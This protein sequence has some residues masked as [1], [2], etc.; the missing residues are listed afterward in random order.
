MLKQVNLYN[1]PRNTGHKAPAL[2]VPTT[3]VKA[4]HPRPGQQSNPDSGLIRFWGPGCGHLNQLTFMMW[5]R[6]ARPERRAAFPH[7]QFKFITKPLSEIGI[8]PPPA[9]SRAKRAQPG[10]KLPARKTG[11]PKLDALLRTK[12]RLGVHWLPALKGTQS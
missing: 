3:S 11:S 8:L 6:S 4:Y 10:R 9:N 1:F 5:A 12:G 2:F 7:L